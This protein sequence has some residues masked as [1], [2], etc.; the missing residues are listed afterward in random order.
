[1]LRLSRSE[2][3]A[4]EYEGLRTKLAGLRE[5]YRLDWGKLQHSPQSLDLLL[6][7][8]DVVRVDRLV[9]TVRVD[10]E[11]RAPAILAYKP[12][13][14]VE[15]Y[16][17]QAGGFT[18]RA[19]RGKVRVTRSVTGQTLVANHVSALGPG[20]FIWVPEKPDV[21][22][23]QQTRDILSSLAQVAAIVIAIRSVR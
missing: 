17:R 19:W 1:M 20:D 21:T 12:G 7:D 15:D 18:G 23:W 9:S 13:L 14:S 5:D 2:L 6:L 8:G 22:A 4:S 10:R 11:V 16:V 3:T